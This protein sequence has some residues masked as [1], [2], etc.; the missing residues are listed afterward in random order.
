MILERI[1]AHKW[2]EVAADEAREG[3]HELKARVMDLGPTRGFARQL[4]DVAASGTAIIAEVKK[5]SPSK[6]I[7]REDF[8]PEVVARAYQQ[9]GAACLSVL[10]DE[11]FFF[12]KLA[13]LQYL[14]Q[15]VPLPLLR[16]DFIVSPYQIW[17]AR[18]YGA[19]AILLIAAALA[20]DELVEYA[21]LAAELGLDVLLEIHSEE[22][23]TQAQ[24]TTAAMIGINN[25]DL[26]TFDT[27]LTVTERLAPWISADRLI[28]AE[29]GIRNRA[30]IERLQVAGARAFLVGES[31][32]RERDIVAKLREL[33]GEDPRA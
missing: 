15:L 6:G 9:G 24:A 27:D 21:D 18:A 3:L 1:L 16:K 4:R 17:Q 23:L 10:T 26:R 14:S 7:I 8:D 5:G 22:E 28:V 13:T 33:Q 19:D 32:M 20:T 11:Q 2:S 29:S 12:G 30:D 31:L 25:R